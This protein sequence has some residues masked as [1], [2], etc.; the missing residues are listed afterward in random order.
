MRKAILAG[1]ADNNPNVR[2]A[3]AV[4]AGL[5]NNPDLA[6]KVA[7]LLGDKYWQVQV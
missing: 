7:K 4:L 3:A 5:S 2:Q 1:I 6:V